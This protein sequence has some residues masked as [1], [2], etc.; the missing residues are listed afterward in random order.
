MSTRIRDSET[1]YG[2]ERRRARQTLEE[3]IQ[4]ELYLRGEMSIREI[5]DRAGVSKSPALRKVLGEM[6]DAGLLV[7]RWTSYKH[8]G[9]LLFS[10]S[11]SA[12]EYYYK[13]ILSMAGCEKGR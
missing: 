1:F 5:A 6:C 10:L 2:S 3:S 8:T 7:C 9:K 4:G 11:P 12:F 13:H